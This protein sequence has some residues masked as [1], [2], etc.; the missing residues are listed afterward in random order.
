MLLG[1]GTTAGVALQAL[2]L[3]FAAP[4]CRA[5]SAGSDGG[6]S[7]AHE[8][9]RTVLRLG[10]WT[11]GFVVANQVA[12]YVVLALAVHAP[13][14]DPVSSYTYAYTFMQM[15]YAVV[16]VSVMSAVTP[17]L[18]E[19]WTVGDLAGVP[20]AADRRAAGQCWRSSSRRRWAC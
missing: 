9:V 20:P 16:A 17:D 12:L 1:L 11:F 6:G 4:R 19:R 5:C 8:A 15:P 2:L 3:L 18:A 7:P 13:G 14:P 10:G